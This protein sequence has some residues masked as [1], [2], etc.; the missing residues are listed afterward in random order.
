MLALGE[1]ARQAGLPVAT[2]K[3][4]LREGLLPEGRLRSTTRADYG[5][6]HL[7]RLRLLRLLREVGDVPVERLRAL[8]TALEQRDGDP[9]AVLAAGTDALSAPRRLP[10]PHAER[11]DELARQLV[12]E[13]GWAEC[14]TEL[15][16][17]AEL[18][19][20]LEQVLAW[21][22]VGLPVRADDLTPYVEAAD[23]VAR[24]D[25]ASMTDAEPADMLV[26]MVVGQVVYGRLLGALR[27]VAEAH[28]AVRRWGED[29]H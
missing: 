15:A 14:P 23:R 18:R 5:H 10:G 13:G 26:Q 27:R 25:I 22:D 24:H 28:H 9:I 17:Q 21:E 2:V 4:Y 11:A 20:V 12:A 16:E 1:L 19:S 29:H 3:Y 7:D 8:V 6:E